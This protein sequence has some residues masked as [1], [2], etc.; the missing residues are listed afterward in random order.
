MGHL[1]QILQKRF[2]LRLVFE[3]ERKSGRIQADFAP[4]S[5]FETRTNLNPPARAVK[6]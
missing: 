4:I 5:S 2:D 1:L 6:P 3:L